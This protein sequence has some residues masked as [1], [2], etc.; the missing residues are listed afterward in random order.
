[1]KKEG[2]IT[3]SKRLLITSE[4]LNDLNSLI[5]KRCSK[6]EWQALLVDGTTITF[7]EFEQVKRHNNFGGTAFRGI[8]CIGRSDD[9][10]TTIEVNISREFPSLK[11][12]GDCRFQFAHD[13]QYTVFREEIQSFFKKCVENE[14]AYQVAKWLSPLVLS[15]IIEYTIFTL[16]DTA[17]ASTSPITASHV[18]SH[19]PLAVLSFLVLLML[20]TKFYDIVFPSIV[21][22]IGE[23]ESL[24]EKSKKLRSNIFWCV[25]VTAIIGIIIDRL[26][27]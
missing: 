24:Y 14:N 4:R 3:T 13:D 23:G 22:A 12:F 26:L 5:S 20:S 27:K 9:F 6:M 1:M 19:L 11:R 7:D 15:G 17:T 16:P 18:A 10:Q 21:F 2:R 8:K 25:I